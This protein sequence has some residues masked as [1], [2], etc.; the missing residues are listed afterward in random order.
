MGIDSLIAVEMRAW[1]VKEVEVDV[2]VM[3]ILGGASMAE[4]VDFVLEN[5]PEKLLSRLDNGADQTKTKGAVSVVNDTHEK[6]ASPEGILANH[7]AEYRPNG[8]VD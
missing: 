6:A 7:D 3:K 1:F 5:L 2:P 8:Q 4:L